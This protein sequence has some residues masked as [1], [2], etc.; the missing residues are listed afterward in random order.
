MINSVSHEDLKEHEN[1]KLTIVIDKDSAVLWCK[2][3][4]EAVFELYTNEEAIIN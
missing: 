2:D 4:D 1:H 3:C